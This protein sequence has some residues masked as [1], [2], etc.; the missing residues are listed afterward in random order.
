MRRQNIFETCRNNWKIINQ[1]WIKE[2]GD[3]DF[4]IM[5]NQLL[6]LKQEY[7]SVEKEYK[8]A[9]HKL[10]STARDRQLKKFLTSCFIDSY[11]IPRIGVG[12]KATLRSFGVETAA[13]ISYGKIRGIPGFG[14]AL[15]NELLIWRHEVE[16]GFRFDPSKGVDMSDRQLVK[17]KFLP[18]LRP[19]ELGL[20]TGLE[21]ITHIQQKI[22]KTR[23]DIYPILESCAKELAQAHA[24]LKPFSF[25]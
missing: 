16:S 1:R 15:T 17:Q 8:L 25:F 20:Q 3:E 6:R 19:L 2:A 14:D 18:R 22:F 4:K 5:F 9:L 23:G 12:R 21:K 13:D 10:E 24:D 7:E 11:S